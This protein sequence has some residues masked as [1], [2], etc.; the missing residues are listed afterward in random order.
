MITIEN[1]EI[2]YLDYLDGNLSEELSEALRLFLMHHPD[3]VIEETDVRLNPEEIDYANKAE[4]K[5]WDE[6]EVITLNNVELFTIAAE[7]KLLSTTK[8]IELSRFTQEHSALQNELSYYTLTK[9]QPNLNWVYTDKNKLKRKNTIVLW[10]WFSAAAVVI[11]LFSITSLFDTNNANVRYT[12]SNEVDLFIS[13]EL[14]EEIQ[15]KSNRVAEQKGSSF[16][17]K[18]RVNDINRSAKGKVKQQKRK[19]PVAIEKLPVRQNTQKVSLPTVLVEPQEI[20][21]KLASGLPKTEP[22]NSMNN[23]IWAVTNLV[24]AVTNKDVDFRTAKE[25]EE[26]TGGFHIKFGTF[27]VYKNNSKKL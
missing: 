16:I 11:L 21:L 26:N 17:E 4:L 13:S 6:D 18:Q 8:Q 24:G 15:W 22:L 19:F 12:K 9:L 1:Y 2:Y 3:L 7:E 14:E 10:P 20:I 23:P 25:T 5:V 27:E